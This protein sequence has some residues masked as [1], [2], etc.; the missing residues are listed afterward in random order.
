MKKYLFF[1]ITVLGNNFA[2]AQKEQIR[3][4]P[5]SPA[6]KEYVAKKDAK[7]Y[8]PEITPE[9]FALGLIPST[10][11]PD[12]SAYYSQTANLKSVQSFPAV[13]D[14]RT[15]GK[16]TP[17]KNQGQCGSCWL[18]PT[19]GSIE[20][21][22]KVQG[23]GEFDLS[24][25]NLKNCHGFDYLPCEG[26][27]RAMAVSY[28]TRSTGPFLESQDPYTAASA[29]CPSGLTPVAYVSDARFLPKNKNAIKQALMDYGAIYN[30]FRW[31][32]ASYNS[33]DYTYYY[34]GTSTELNHA[35]LIVG[36]DDNKVTAG[37]TGAWIIKNSWGASW[38]QS[39]F[40]Y[41][42]YNDTKA[43]SDATYYPIRTDYD[44]NAKISCY[45]QLGMTTS[46]GYGSSTGY[47]MVKY[48]PAG[49]EQIT[50]VGT[51]VPASNAKVTIEIY[52]T[53]SGTTLSASLGSI[54]QKT[55]A[56]PG[57][58]TFD[59]PTP[60]NVTAGD[61]YFIKIKYYTPGTTFP[62]PV[63]SKIS[64][65]TGNVVTEA[66][67]CWISS[68]GYSWTAVGSNTS[69]KYDVCIKSYTKTESCTPIA[70]AAA[71]PVTSAG[72][73]GGSTTFSVTPAGSGYNYQ[74]KVSSNG[75]SWTNLTNTG[76]YSDVNTNTLSISGITSSLNY[77]KYRC[78]VANA[79]SSVNSNS[80]K[81]FVTNAPNVTNQ[82]GNK[83]IIS[84][85]NTTFT[86]SATGTGKTY[87][88][89]ISANG[90]STWTNL[91]HSSTYSNVTGL[92]LKITG[93]T[94]ALSGKKYRCVITN[95]C[96]T[97]NTNAATLNIT[98]S[99]KSLTVTDENSLYLPIMDE[100]VLLAVDQVDN[101]EEAASLGYNYPN[102]FTRFTS[103]TYNLSEDAAVTIEIYNVLGKQISVLVNAHKAAGS[104]QVEFDGTDLPA[105]YY[106]YTLKASG[107]TKVFSQT[108]M[109]VVI[110]D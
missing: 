107:K 7:A 45:D 30:T 57:Y 32:A 12:F 47:G 44:A 93:A 16:I 86:F 6:F 68:A 63:E 20:S 9:G 73:V 98:P 35:V 28:L 95:F 99:N 38:G 69:K 108:R 34:N 24:E 60:I 56:L 5:L 105:G 110:K 31:E 25:D 74:W 92:T 55:C 58:Y 77:K 97:V 2:S 80:V 70:S 62:I 36:W 40:F 46:M 59:L 71:S 83:T 76:Y 8:S 64:G 94:I 22:W 90:G 88:W 15:N 85:N 42:S 75:T 91:T 61:D 100:N 3:E 17:V 19:M 67:K 50:K 102:P 1:L 26:G 54:P 11:E 41:I 29:G 81:L 96:G 109:M 101:D 51:W 78:A 23:L 79:C 82:P 103:I 27:S 33:A 13:Y 43:T 84:G 37:G 48:I 65:Y 104:Y 53:F 49:N 21:N 14:M 39:G 52:N 4:A 18:F 87:K 72:C 10:F 106:T 66:G 89:Q